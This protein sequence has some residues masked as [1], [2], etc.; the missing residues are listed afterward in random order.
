MRRGGVETPLFQV[1]DRVPPTGYVT[2]EGTERRRTVVGT[3]C[4]VFGRFWVRNLAILSQNSF[5]LSPSS[6]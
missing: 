2:I 4:F 3:P 5:F 1:L 6:K